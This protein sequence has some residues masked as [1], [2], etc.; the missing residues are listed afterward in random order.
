MASFSSSVAAVSASRSVPSNDTDTG[1]PK[2]ENAAKLRFSAPYTVPTFW[3]T[4]ALMSIDRMLRRSPSRSCTLIS[5]LWAA[6][7][8][9][10][11]TARIT[12][13]LSSRS[14]LS[15]SLT[16][17][18]CAS[19]A[20][21]SAAVTS[22]RVPLTMDKFTVRLSPSMNGKN[23]VLTKP[24]PINPGTV[25]MNNATMLANEIQGWSS[26][27]RKTGAYSRFFKK[28]MTRRMPRSTALGLKSRRRALLCPTWAGKMNA[29][30]TKLNSS[31]SMMT[32]AM[33]RKK[34]P[35]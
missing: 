14:A 32:L 17:Q 30:S 31:V 9:R 1:R 33:S 22:S 23:V 11:S 35:N 12:S 10:L 34:S 7:P 16:S 15:V 5:P 13:K 8:T 27:N 29:P 21:S 6:G 3:R 26:A 24:L 2:G 20:S 28:S 18:M 19:I 4:I 25:I